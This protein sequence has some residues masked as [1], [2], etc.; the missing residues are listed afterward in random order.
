MFWH[1]R[2]SAGSLVRLSAGDVGEA[3]VFAAV[4]SRRRSAGEV[5]IPSSFF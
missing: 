2:P 5:P 4:A 1:F 3:A